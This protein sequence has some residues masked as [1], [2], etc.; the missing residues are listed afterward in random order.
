[1]FGEEAID[2]AVAMVHDLQGGIMVPVR[3]GRPTQLSYVTMCGVLNLS[4]HGPRSIAGWYPVYV[5]LTDAVADATGGTVEWVFPGGS[6]VAMYMP[7]MPI[8]TSGVTCR[9]DSVCAANAA[10][11]APTSPAAPPGV[12]SFAGAAL[13]AFGI[14]PPSGAPALLT[15]ATVMVPASVLTQP[16]I[17]SISSCV[18]SQVNAAVSPV[19]MAGFAAAP[20]ANVAKISVSVGWTLRSLTRALSSVQLRAVLD[21]AAALLPAGTGTISA[22][23]YGA[24]PPTVSLIVAGLPPSLAS[25]QS[26][27]S[28]LSIGTSLSL[29]SR[30]LATS[31]LPGLTAVVVSSS[32]A[33]APAVNVTLSVSSTLLPGVS[34]G[35]LTD[36][37]A[38]SLAIGTPPSCQRSTSTANGLIY[39]PFTSMGNTSA[40]LPWPVFS[41]QAACYQ[42]SSGPPVAAPPPPLS[43]ADDVSGLLYFPGSPEADVQMAVAAAAG[44]PAAAVE[45]DELPAAQSTDPS[46]DASRPMYAYSINGFGDGFG[47][48]DTANCVVVGITPTLPLVS[49]VPGTPPRAVVILPYIPSAVAIINVKARP[50]SLSPMP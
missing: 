34:T 30:G 35:P 41:P 25:A 2:P 49:G 23:Q 45:V 17:N 43:A 47:G 19:V 10:R 50:G 32:A 29:I 7:S 28:S 44:V 31:T 15:N 26:V 14:L 12:V 22:T 48:L 37:L 36:A 4:P 18:L 42:A 33:Y 9:D 38:Y 6:R 5:L 1:M 11:G 13:P 24:S 20:T 21:A 16:L 46:V 3:A 39:Y 40:A 8:S 27:I